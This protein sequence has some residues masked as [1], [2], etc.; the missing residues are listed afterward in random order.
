MDAI[1]QK[2][3]FLEGYKKYV[4]NVL[5]PT[6]C[7]VKKIFKR[8]KEDESWGI[9]SNSSASLSPINWYAT[10]IKRPESLVD[11]ILSQEAT[12][13]DGLAES[14]LRIINDAFACRIIVFCLRDLS[15][16]HNRI[17]H[18]SCFEI[19]TQDEPYQFDLDNAFVEQSG[20]QELENRGR[21]TGYKAIHYIVRL[22]ESSAPV[23]ERPWFEIQVKTLVQH[24]WSEIEHL[25]G[26]K[27]AGKHN[28]N[29][30]QNKKRQ[31]KIISSLLSAIDDH[32][33]LLFE[34]ALHKQENPDYNFDTVITT[35]ILPDLLKKKGI[36]SSQSKI[37]KTR[38]ILSDY[39]I[40]SVEDFE[41]A[42]SRERI[43]I[44]REVF[45]KVSG[46]P[47]TPDELIVNLAACKE[48]E[49]NSLL[50]DSIQVQIAY[51]AASDELRNMKC[52]CD[53][54]KQKGI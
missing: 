8:W 22:T 25:L 49:D 2:R 30:E 7:E 44:I 52:S 16:V 3:S 9:N 41:K 12:F 18:S 23:Q 10:R 5:Q 46:N 51:K 32:F 40:Y 4:N 28:T 53:Q 14:S 36:I 26:Y 6:K 43:N 42:I 19:S 54:D 21:G 37:E 38:R 29:H 15:L 47:P 39:E 48:I 17:M 35:D 45:E 34:D 13:P 33:D 31:F 27:P 20:L 1:E 50:V 24:A 11:K